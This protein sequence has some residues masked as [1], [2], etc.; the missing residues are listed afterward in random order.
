MPVPESLPL[1]EI[2][3][4]RD[5]R[6]I[7]VRIALQSVLVARGFGAPGA[8][9]LDWVES[10]GL[11]GALEDEERACLDGELSEEEENE[12]CWRQESLYLLAWS[13][14]V[15]DR[16]PPPF[17][18]CEL[19]AILGDIPPE[20]PF[21]AFSDG[22]ARR[23]DEDLRQQLDLHFCAHHALRHPELWP[24]DAHP[25]PLNLGVVLERRRALQWLAAPGSWSGQRLDA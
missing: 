21:G 8:R 17:E 6:E 13:V 22:V 11:T 9:L 12:L 18:F 16:L 24:G 5:P 4:L 3:G 10:Q 7:A 23:S 20:A 15:A 14:G 19:D 1:L 25:G 2:G